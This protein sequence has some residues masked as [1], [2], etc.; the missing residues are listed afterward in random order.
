MIYKYITD[1]YMGQE[2][3]RRVVAKR[4]DPQALLRLPPDLLKKIDQVAASNGR[5]RNTEIVVRL[6][7]SVAAEEAAPATS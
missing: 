2:M 6:R 5:S 1:I 7:Q 3:N 4:K